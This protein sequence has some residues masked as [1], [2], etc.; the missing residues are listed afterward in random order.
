MKREP[1]RLQ[2]KGVFALAIPQF[3]SVAGKLVK[4]RSSSF[5]VLREACVGVPAF[6]QLKSLKG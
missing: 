5:C 1:G 4:T 6:A 3:P 2:R